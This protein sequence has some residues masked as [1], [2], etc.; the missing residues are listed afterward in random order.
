[1][2]IFEIGH[3]SYSCGRANKE[4]FKYDD[5]MSILQARSSCER[6]KKKIS[7]FNN[8]RLRVDGKI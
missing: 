6:G 7:V 8:A 4:V 2:E 3:V 5:I 1:M